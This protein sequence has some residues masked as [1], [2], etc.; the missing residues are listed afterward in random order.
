M[1]TDC[2][3]RL[4]PNEGNILLPRRRGAVLQSHPFRQSELGMSGL[5]F[6]RRIAQVQGWV[7]VH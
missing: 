4:F 5:G 7:R 3:C 1:Y 6:L 2:L